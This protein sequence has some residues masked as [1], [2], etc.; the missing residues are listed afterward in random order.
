MILAWLGLAL[1]RPVDGVVVTQGGN[2]TLGG[3]SL[4]LPDGTVVVADDRGRFHL[5]LPDD[6]PVDRQARDAWPTLTVSAEGYRDAQLPALP[7]R[8]GRWVI[9]LALAPAENEIV[10]ESFRPTG[11]LTRQP[12]DAEMAFETPGTY[13]DAVRLIQALPGV[14][15]QR[16]YSPTSGDLTVRGS[17]P[18]DNRYYVDGIEV[19]YLYHF[20]QY[21][22][23]VPA[24]SLD[25]LELFS[26]TFS[27]KYGDSA[28]AIVEA[29]TRSDRPD[30]V[31]GSASLNFVMLGAD[32]RIPVPNK[33]WWVSVSGRRSYQDLVGET[34]L[35]YPKWP[36]FYDAAVRAQ[37]DGD[38]GS[39]QIFFTGAGDAY[40]RAVGELDVL[41]PVDQTRAP[42]LDYRHDFQILGVQHRWGLGRFVVGVVHD[43]ER[44]AVSVGGHANVRSLVVAS[45]LDAR[46][47]L[48]DD[49]TLEVG[50]EAKPEFTW[51]D[52]RSAGVYGPLVQRE[53]PETNW[54][55]DF[56]AQAT[57]RFRAGLYAQLNAR[58]G[59]VRL[60]PGLRAGADL[61]GGA[62]P[63][64]VGTLEPRFAMRA[65][66]ADATEL[67]FAAG[68]YQ[69][70]PETNVALATPRSLPTTDS[71]Q[72]GAGIE[73]TVYQRLEF[74]LEGFY[75]TS[76][77]VIVLPASGPP[78][79]WDHGRAFG[80]EFV[81][82]YRLREVFF[83]WAQVAA[84][85]SLAIDADGQ[86][87]PTQADQPIA[88]GLVASWNIL[89]PL[90]VAVR[91]RGASGLPYTAIVGSTYDATDDSWIPTF[92][93]L[94]GIR[95]PFY[96][97]IDLHLAYT[98][99]LPRWSL[100]AS[101][102]VWIV[103]KPSAPIYPTWNYDFSEAGFV[104]GPQVLP[105]LGLRAAW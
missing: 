47:P 71:W 2:A 14:A 70:R 28:G 104:I 101:A 67:R 95:M 16:E 80:G 24:S 65:R 83:L 72:V 55:A 94:N 5:D 46:A 58:I 6:E 39:T 11:D 63:Q 90:N 21:A 23:V 60:I 3:A 42:S 102:D 35:Q 96:Q 8:R 18:G 77:D 25:Q 22:S 92:G 10:I 38:N 57:P 30:H 103:P 45:R 9:A 88:G 53:A 93:A 100:T 59:R 82:R 15:V 37:H 40:A 52:V 74:G 1:A 105:L 48:S 34:S 86:A 81:M 64:A 98:W 97:K 36:T 79:V 56:S 85:R 84:G 17:L 12:V 89:A 73:Q 43:D 49:A 61:L 26:S 78:Q 68:R 33:R 54:Q 62:V 19:P 51:I 99:N 32:V 29:S 7:P 87:A 4:T 13:D 27:A 91:W 31:T 66:V 44:A 75:K 20:N 69:Q 76:S 50:Y 41:D